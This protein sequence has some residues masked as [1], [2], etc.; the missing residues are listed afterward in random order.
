MNLWYLDLSLNALTG[1]IPGELGNLVSLEELHLGANELTGPIPGELEN[2]ANLEE[3][4]LLGNDLTGP[5]PGELGS[6]VNLESLRLDGN[7]LTGPIPGELGNLASLRSLLL[8]LNALTGPIPGELG[9]LTNLRSLHLARNA[10]TGPI[11][12]ELGNLVNLKQLVL[13]SSDLTGPIPGELL[14]LT[15]LAWLDLSHNW[16]LSGSLPPVERFPHLERVDL[17]VTQA[18]ATAGWWDRATTIELNVR[19]CK[20][21][22]DVTIDV[23]VFYTL[24][25][26]EAVGDGAAIEAVIDL[27]IAEANQAFAA[28][29]VHHRLKLVERSEIA[30]NETG[31]ILDVYR[32]IHPSDGH[33]DEVHAVRDR[34]GADL[35]HLIVGEFG[36]CGLSVRPGAFGLTRYDCGGGTF[37]HE[38]GHNMGLRHD[39][40]R[41]HWDGGATPPDPAY[42]YVNPPALVTGTARSRHWRTLMAYRNQCVDEAYTRCPPLFRFSNPLQ[43]YNGDPLGVAYG[44]GAGVT[45]PA[46]AVAVLNATGSAV[47][48]WRDRPPPNRPPTAAGT[49]PD[50]ALT[51][52]GTLD[53]D[54][55]LAFVDPDGAP[56][57]YTVSSSAPDVVT[58]RAAGARVTLT[59][60]SEGMATIRVRATDPGGLSAIQ[61]FAVTVEATVSMPFTDP[62]RPGVTPIRAVHFTELRARIDALRSAAG[63]VRFPWTDPVL[64]AGVTRVRRVHLLELR[65]ALAEGYGEAGRTAPRWTDPAPA[66]GMTPIRAAHLIELRAAVVAL[67]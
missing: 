31:D 44:E 25:A 4:T 18:C 10:L 30:Y 51:L 42:G 38:L 16:G 7:A 27:R 52:H 43:N 6:L 13:Y 61:A 56:L 60:V 45:G 32:L 33:M 36:L 66:G 57:T 12:S 41:V 28:S 17:L 34:V 67:E 9:N 8:S 55:S 35:V 49:L 50:R 53:V 58:V 54:V 59:A 11:P 64:R 37:A 5:I 39:R 26:R 47:A 1:P 22:P 62:L 2:L 15:N 48:R 20:T 23:A 21:G 65:V 19:P 40:Y 3:L 63:L 29:G 24:A 14:S 46:D